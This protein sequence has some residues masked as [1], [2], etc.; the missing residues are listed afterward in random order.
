MAGGAAMLRGLWAEFL[1][2]KI[3][4]PGEGEEA[5][6]GAGQGAAGGPQGDMA[7]FFVPLWQRWDQRPAE[8][9]EGSGALPTEEAEGN[10]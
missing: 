8:E 3:K 2:G 7:L 9:Q 6:E 10:G 4:S 1:A 5:R